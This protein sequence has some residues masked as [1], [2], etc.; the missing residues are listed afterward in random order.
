MSEDMVNRL[1]DLVGEVTRRDASCV[2][3]DDDLVA[4]LGIDSLESLRVLALVEKRF[5]ARF[6]DDEVGD[7]RTLRRLAQAVERRKR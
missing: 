6:D 1:R 3:P 7:V 2:G 5:G 4:A